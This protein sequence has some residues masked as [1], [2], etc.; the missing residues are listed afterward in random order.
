[1]FLWDQ[2]FFIFMEILGYE[3]TNFSKL[4]KFLIQNACILI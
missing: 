2:M 4:I 3:L 1:M